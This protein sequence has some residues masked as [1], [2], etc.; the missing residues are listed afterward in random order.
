MR[1]FLALNAMIIVSARYYA[2]IQV[3]FEN[4][5]LHKKD[6][7]AQ[8]K[9][10]KHTLYDLKIILYYNFRF[11]AV[12]MWIVDFRVMILCRLVYD[13]YLLE[14]SVAFFCLLIYLLYF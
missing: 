1:D 2:W 4:I 7:S 8:G 3:Y 9:K 12:K 6:V 11:A 10:L 14:E 5:L 13:Y